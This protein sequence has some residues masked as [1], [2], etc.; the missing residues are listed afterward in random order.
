MIVQIINYVFQTK[1]FVYIIEKYFSTENLSVVFTEKL[2]FLKKNCF[3]YFLI[4]LYS[5]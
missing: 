1:I 4:K 2:F 3:M 5:F